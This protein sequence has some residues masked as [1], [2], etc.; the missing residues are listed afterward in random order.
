MAKSGLDRMSLIIG[1]LEGQLAEL[2]RMSA[3]KAAAHLDAAI[4]QL[5]RDQRKGPQ[6]ADYPHLVHVEP[7]SRA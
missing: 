2:D 4:Q 3:D 6:F 7:A 5:R 1:I